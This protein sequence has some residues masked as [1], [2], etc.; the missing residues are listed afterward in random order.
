MQYRQSNQSDLLTI[1]SYQESL[2]SNCKGINKLNRV[3]KWESFRDK[4]EQLLGYK[5]RE[6]NRGRPPFDPVLMF[7]ILIL[8]KYYDLSDQAT[9]DQIRDRLSFMNFLNLKIG[10]AIPD[11]NTIWDFRNALEKDGLNGTQVLFEHF[12]RLL[13]ANKLIGRE[14]SIVD[15]TFVDAPVQHNTREQNEQ[16]KQGEVPDGFTSDNAKGRQKDCEARWALKNKESHYGFK[17]HAKAD[18]KNKL[19]ISYAT[20]AANVHDSQMFKQLVDKEDNALLADAAY[21]SEENE[22]YLL[23]ECDCNEFMQIKAKPKVGLTAEQKCLNKARSRI[24]VRIEHI[25]GRMS[26]M[27]MH[28]LRTIGLVRAHQHNGLCNLLYNMDRYA[29]LCP[30]TAI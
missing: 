24:R 13:Q 23:H 21:S 5:D 2:K 27:G 6:S 9:E 10:D 26:Q 28:R 4:L 11:A 20:T 3:I 8:Q 25:F 12:E 1:M 15:A 7:K 29:F 19:V 22:A 17:N 16:I 30:N 14:G 18:A